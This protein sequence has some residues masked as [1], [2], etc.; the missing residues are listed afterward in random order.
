MGRCRCAGASAAGYSAIR[1]NLR[2]VADVL[3]GERL[4][5]IST[6]VG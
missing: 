6:E 3:E 1:R 4:D 2:G 5:N